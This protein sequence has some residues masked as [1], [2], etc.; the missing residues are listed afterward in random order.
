MKSPVSFAMSWSRRVGRDGT[1]GE[2]T[3]DVGEGGGILNQ[4]LIIPV[5]GSWLL[6]YYH[7]FSY[8]LNPS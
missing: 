7:L 3:E 1:K 8:S 5:A 6:F 2:E 4:D